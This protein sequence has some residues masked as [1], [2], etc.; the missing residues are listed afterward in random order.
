MI[1]QLVLTLAAVSALL[2]A[3]GYFSGM[4]IGLYALNRVRHR[5][6]LRQKDARARTV[7]AFLDRPER[8][9][10]T[11]LVGNNIVNAT[12]T[13]LVTFFFVRLLQGSSDLAIVVSGGLTAASVGSSLLAVGP[14]A[15]LLTTL[16]ISPALFMLGE[17]APKDLFRRHADWLV[18]RLG[19][20]TSL[21]ALALRPLSWPLEIASR[22]IQRRLLPRHKE[23]ETTGGAD[24]LVHVLASGAEA[25]VL[26]DYQDRMARNVVALRGRRLADV[27]IP[28]RDVVAVSAASSTEAAQEVARERGVTRMPLFDRHRHDWVGIVDIFDLW[29]GDDLDTGLRERCR[30]V[31]RLSPHLTVEI[32]IGRI[33]RSRQPMAFVVQGS[34][35]L[36]LVTLKDLVEEI[37]GELQDL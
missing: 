6:R 37:V 30:D 4:E 29:P 34:R 36:G 1:S 31:P 27:M 33:R 5:I 19:P 17:V 10:S 25:G 22:V 11:V 16:C 20:F 9:I 28:T 18:Y 24:F 12:M 14:R 32:A 13:A 15:E 3:S 2:L 35:C 7:Q 26:T 21:V 23:Q 8:F